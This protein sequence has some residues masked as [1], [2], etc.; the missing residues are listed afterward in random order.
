[1]S[2]AAFLIELNQ[3]VAACRPVATCFR[4]L[5]ADETIFLVT[6]RFRKRD[7]TGL[8][9]AETRDLAAQLGAALVEVDT[10]LD[11]VR[12]LAGRSGALVSASET[13]LDAHGFNHKV[14]LAAPAGFTRITLQ[15]GLE[16][17]GFNHNEAHD[18]A[19]GMRVGMACDIAASWFPLGRLH[20]V[21]S[22]QRDKVMMVGPPFGLSHPPVFGRPWRWRNGADPMHGLVCENLHSVR[23][24]QSARVEFIDAL[25]EFAAALALRDGSAELRAHPG[26]RYA[27]KNRI[28]LPPNVSLN[29]APLYRQSLDKFGFGI[30]APSSVLLDMVWAGIPT[31]VW[32]DG[33]LDIG[34]YEGLTVVSDVDDW[35]RFAEAATRDPAPFLDAQRR[36][37][38]GLGIPADIPALYR[39]LYDVAM[40]PPA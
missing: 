5:G 11:V 10:V 21:R 7:A 2:T 1:M 26:G 9:F 14:F 39:D 13:D 33:A 37:V 22:D 12:A 27:E 36:Y 6:S 19:F 35:V 40:G 15:H 34:I 3:D 17:L 4:D 29:R 31:A 23:F 30:S 38:A 16:C 8:W 32:T 28:E 25:T 20:S 18:R 24:G